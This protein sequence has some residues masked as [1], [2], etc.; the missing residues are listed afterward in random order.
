MSLLDAQIQAQKFHSSLGRCDDLSI[1]PSF[2][3]GR[4]ARRS[5]GEIGAF[6]PRRQERQ[7]RAAIEKPRFYEWRPVG[8][9][10]GRGWSNL[11]GFFGHYETVNGCYYRFI[12]RGV[13]DAMF[14]AVSV[15]ADLEWLMI[16]STTIRAHQ[17]AA[18]ARS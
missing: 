18:G 3:K 12:E 13:F 6:H 9:R 14:A 4:I 11:P 16:D 10:F 7:A 8:C 15:D 17:R 5:M 2:D 1:V